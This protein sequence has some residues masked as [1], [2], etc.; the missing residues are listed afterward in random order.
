[1]KDLDKELEKILEECVASHPKPPHV[2]L[3]R[4]DF[5]DR[6]K[7]LIKS[8]LLDALPK[9]RPRKGYEDKPESTWKDFGYEQALKTIK[10][11]LGY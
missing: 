2:V 7:S 9:E 3:Y 8:T 6:L 5:M 1:M 10:D 4:Y 11:K